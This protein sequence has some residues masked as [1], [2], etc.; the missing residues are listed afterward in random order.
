MYMKNTFLAKLTV[1]ACASCNGRVTGST[2]AC[3]TG[4]L[5]VGATVVRGGA[6]PDLS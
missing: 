1:N 5:H 4:T 6:G 3:A 2:N